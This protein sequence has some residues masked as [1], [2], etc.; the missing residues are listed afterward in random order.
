MPTLVAENVSNSSPPGGGRP[1][2][3]SATGLGSS[4]VIIR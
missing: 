1:R 3:S 4:A 2:A